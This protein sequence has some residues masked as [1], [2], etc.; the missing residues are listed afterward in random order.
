MRMHKLLVTLAFSMI[1]N[2][3]TVGA[4]DGQGFKLSRLVDSEAAPFDLVYACMT[5]KRQVSILKLPESERH[6]ERKELEIYLIFM[7]DGGFLIET[8]GDGVLAETYGPV[9]QRETYLNRYS[10][11]LELF[12]TDL[13]DYHKFVLTGGRHSRKGFTSTIMLDKDVMIGTVA[14]SSTSMDGTVK[15][16]KEGFG[17]QQVYPS[18]G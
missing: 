16:R 3:E 2:I 12:Y 1:M 11:T 7:K 5:T 4:D 17:C 6:A 18:I 15:I 14:K 9:T 13:G 8:N 10:S